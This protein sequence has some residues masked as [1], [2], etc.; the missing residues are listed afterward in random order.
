MRI[1]LSQPAPRARNL[2]EA[3]ALIDELWLVLRAQ[4]Q[5]IQE[6]DRQIAALTARVQ[7][8]EEQLRTNPRNSF[9]P[10]AADPHRPP[11]NKPPSGKKRGA[12]PGHSGKART[13][14]P[15]EQVMHIHDCVPGPCPACG[16]TMRITG[17]CARHQ[18]IELPPM[19]P[20]VTAYR[21][22]TGACRI[23]GQLCEAGLPPGVSPRIAGPHLLAAIG[24]LTGSYHLSKRQV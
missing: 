22:F 21:L 5:Q 19:T 4:M 6:R 24:T 14:L 12:Q 3:Q 16:G 20:V 15:P 17:L 7:T 10:P 1:D 23:C 2:E 9:T 18:V 8:L 11:A 13:L